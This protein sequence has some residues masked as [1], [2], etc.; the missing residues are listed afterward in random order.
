MKGTSVHIRPH[1]ELDRAGEDR[2]ARS[3][4][5]DQPVGALGADG[6]IATRSPS[7][8]AAIHVLFELGRPVGSD[9]V[10]F[11][12][13]QPC[14]SRPNEDWYPNVNLFED[15]SSAERWSQE[16]GMAGRVVTLEEGTD[17]G[18]V[19]WRPLVADQEGRQGGH[20]RP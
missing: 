18:A 9:A 15:A 3:T 11:L 4:N 20:L 5:S 7:S 13:D 6:V 16:H 10:Q 8:G 17:L 19:E 2:R 12:A 1:L 14:C